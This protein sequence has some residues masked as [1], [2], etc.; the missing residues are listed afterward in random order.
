MRL[1]TS[2]NCAGEPAVGPG[3][4]A[5]EM[6]AMESCRANTGAA[7]PRLAVTLRGPCRR[8]APSPAGKGTVSR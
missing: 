1:V 3:S 7:G 5:P 8:P 4:P 6:L 2:S